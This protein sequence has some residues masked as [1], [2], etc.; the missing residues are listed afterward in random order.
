MNEKHAR[1]W[2]ATGEPLRMDSLQTEGQ[3]WP[4]TESPMSKNTQPQLLGLCVCRFSQVC[5]SQD[6]CWSGRSRCILFTAP[7]SK[8]SGK[9][10]FQKWGQ[11]GWSMGRVLL[12]ARRSEFT[13]LELPCFFWMSLQNEKGGTGRSIGPRQ[14]AGNKSLL[15]NRN[16]LSLSHR[17]PDQVLLVNLFYLRVSQKILWENSLGKARKILWDITGKDSEPSSHHHCYYYYY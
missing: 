15:F 3:P 14:I 9:W 7:R 11:A 4:A 17:D 2:K 10:E 16:F 6:T 5:I 13:S 8:H 1:E 12:G